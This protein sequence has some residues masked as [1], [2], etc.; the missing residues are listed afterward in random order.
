MEHCEG[1]P[2]RVAAMG[3]LVGDWYLHFREFQPS[4]VFLYYSN[5]L[6]WVEKQSTILDLSI[7]WYDP[8]MAFLGS[9]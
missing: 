1:E 9:F 7:P 3:P 8:I 6:F 2:H 4:A 5:C